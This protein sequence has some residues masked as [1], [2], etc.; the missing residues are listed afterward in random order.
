MLRN[1]LN[2]HVL[3]NLTFALVI[4]LGIMAYNAMPRA[5][6]PEINFNWVN[7]LTVMPGASSTEIEK[8]ITDPIEEKISSSIKDLRFVS[9]T[10]RDNASNILVRFEGLSDAEFTERMTDLRREIQNVYTSQLP[11][12]ASDPDIREITTSS[13]FPTAVLALTT[14]SFDDDFRFYSENLKKTLERMPGIDE[15]QAIGLEDPELRIA[16]HPERLEGLG[17]SPADLADTVSAYFRDVSIGDIETE[18][19]RWLVRLEGTSGSLEDIEAFPIVSANGIVEL[20]TIAD[21]YRTHAEG[22]SL[23]SY[24]GRPAIKFNI[25]KQSNANILELLDHLQ[26]FIADEN[27]LITGQG[28]Q[29]TL[30]DDQTI[31]TR[32]AIALMQNNAM[33]GLALV[34]LVI[35]LFLGSRI[36]LLTSIGIPFTLCGTFA[37][38]HIM[39]MSVNN[40]VLLGVLIALGM[41]VDDA[42]VVVEAIYYRIQR[43]TDAMTAAIEALQEVAAPVLTSVMTTMSAFLPLIFLPGILGEFMKVIPIVV[44]LAL[45]ISLL[46]AFWMLP[47]HVAAVNVKT[48]STSRMQRFRRNFTRSIRHQYSL[49]L[50]SALRRPWISFGGVM[51]NFILALLLIFS[52]LVTFNFFAADPFRVMYLNSELPQ[53]ST[54]EQSLEVAEELHDI[55]LSTLT[56][57]ELRASIT[58]SGTLLTRTEP[59]FGDNLSQ[60]LI[61]FKPDQPGMRSVSE[62][63]NAIEE[64]VGT[65]YKGS[66]VSVFMVEN[67]PPIGKPISAKVRGSDFD[68]INAAVEQLVNYMEQRPEFNNISIDFKPGSPEFRLSLDGDA[69]KR[70]GISP[71]TVT[72]S[73]QGFVDGELIGQYQYRGEEVDVRLLAKQN[74]TA[75]V[76]QLLR[77]TIADNRGQPIE[78]GSLVNAEYGTGYQNIRHYNFQRTI[79]IEADIDDELIDTVAANQLIDDYWKTIQLQHPSISIDYTGAL[80][81][82]QESLDGIAMLFA[83][84]I[85]VIY[86]ILGT[87]F[88]SYLQPLLVLTA[89]P[90]AMTGVVFGLAITGNPMSLFSM[91]GIVALSGIAV[92]SAIVLISAANNRIENG[93]GLL[94]ATIFAARRRVIPVLITSFTTIA[95]LFSLAAGFAGKSLLWGPIATAIV[96]GLLFSTGLVLVMVPLI[97]FLAYRYSHRLSSEK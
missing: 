89:I 84:G 28:Y 22:S 88:R 33:I 16:F 34:V 97:Y 2:N 20:G 15:A 74:A 36:S 85:G 75:D 8:R 40:S 69:I 27:I 10:S 94:H 45:A 80:D 38:I 7:I 47:A 92:N 73:L 11:A 62:M 53:G 3:A 26:A 81:D 79:T 78:L 59:L 71:H 91:Y 12:E 29:L 39:G 83:L 93:M 51:A 43:G 90:L 76:E 95:G 6:D 24:Q 13:G 60:S 68:K 44:S 17:L 35:F 48:S 31:T 4:T 50:I 32:E 77:Q 41:I 55:A 72:R 52:G 1:F 82:I 14:S 23:T 65:E 19:G 64:A 57:E 63:I 87:Q 25:I 42:V 21:V 49:I 70:A 54:L 18:K 9:S 30:I 66:R 58:W 86:M 37:V 56:E 61:T 67:G 46:E 96:S 5:A